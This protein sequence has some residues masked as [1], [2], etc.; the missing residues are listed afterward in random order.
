MDRGAKELELTVDC[1]PNIG[2]RRRRMKVAGGFLVATATLVLFLTLLA[3]NASTPYFVFVAPLAL[4][5][6]LY[7]F[8]AK[9]RTC[10]V[11]AALKVRELDDAVTKERIA[12]EW[13]VAVQRQARK[14]WVETLTTTAAI[15]AVAV[16]IALLR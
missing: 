6:A 2:F 10:V 7:F 8:Q 9:E 11:L 16:V 3:R 12:G 5:A 14:V 4:L 15:T 1:V 13:L